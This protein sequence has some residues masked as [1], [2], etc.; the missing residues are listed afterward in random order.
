MTKRNNFLAPAQKF[1]KQSLN[2]RFQKYFRI[3]QSDIYFECIDNKTGI[4]YV[5]R[6]KKI[7][8]KNTY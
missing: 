2:V 4:T 8:V 7:E 1:K 5:N 3:C 6:Q